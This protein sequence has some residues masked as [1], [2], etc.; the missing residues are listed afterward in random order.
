MAA[1]SVRDPPAVVAD[2]EDEEDGLP[3]RLHGC[4]QHVQAR[5]QHE[6]KERRGPAPTFIYYAEE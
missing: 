6:I 4:F 5:L 1:S 3:P 2:L